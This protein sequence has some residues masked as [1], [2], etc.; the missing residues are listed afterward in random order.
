MCEYVLGMH[1]DTGIFETIS[2][3][4]GEQPD[5]LLSE[6][7]AIEQ[8]NG[9][10]AYNI[11]TLVGADAAGDARGFATFC[12][13]NFTVFDFRFIRSMLDRGLEKDAAVWDRNRIYSFD[14]CQFYMQITDDKPAGSYRASKRAGIDTDVAHT[15]VDDARRMVRLTRNHFDI[16]IEPVDPAA[17]AHAGAERSGLRKAVHRVG[18]AARAVRDIWRDT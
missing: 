16:G 15:A 17:T 18:N 8:L 10:I 4:S 12:G 2:D 11:D 14:P 7:A 1:C 13:R 6:R 9:F 3:Y 5:N